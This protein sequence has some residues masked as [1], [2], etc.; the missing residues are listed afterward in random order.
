M[1]LLDKADFVLASEHAADVKTCNLLIQRLND[2]LED[3]CAGASLPTEEIVSEWQN[4]TRKLAIADK[5]GVQLSTSLESALESYKTKFSATA[6]LVPA[7]APAPASAWAMYDAPAPAPAPT[8]APAHAPATA[9]A[10]TP[11]PTPLKRSASEANLGVNVDANTNTRHQHRKFG[12]KSLPEV[13]RS[14]LINAQ[15]WR[16][17][18]TA[19]ADTSKE[20]LD[21]GRII[22]VSD[23]HGEAMFLVTSS[24]HPSGFSFDAPTTAGFL[25][26]FDEDKNDRIRQGLEPAGVAAKKAE[27]GACRRPSRLMWGQGGRCERCRRETRR[28]STR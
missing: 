14:P 16:N 5:T 17:L 6:A 2:F 4:E 23:V 25:L 20:A 11:A 28:I 10:P 15:F 8:A 13:Q 21:Y 18:D 26:A 24:I 19:Q 7:P 27:V 9:P 22:D 3:A 1:I 12:G